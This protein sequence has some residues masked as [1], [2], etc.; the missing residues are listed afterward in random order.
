MNIYIRNFF[1]LLFTF[2][3]INLCTYIF[4]VTLYAVE[5]NLNIAVTHKT[6][7]DVKPGDIVSVSAQDGVLVPAQVT[8]D[9]KMFGVYIESPAFVLRTSATKPITRSG[10]ALVNVTTLSGEIN[11][12][13][14]LTSSPIKG[15]G[16]KAN[17]LGGF[18]LGIALDKFTQNDGTKLEY[19]KKT[20]AKG[21]I[22]VEV[23]IGPASPALTKTSG[24]LFGTAKQLMVNLLFN[25]SATRQAEKIIRYI[26]ASLVAIIVILI[27]FNTFG[28]NITRGIEAI[29]RNPL[30]KFSIQSMIVLNVV[31]IALVSLGGIILS[32]AILSL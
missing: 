10:V 11:P 16:Q 8:S 21:Q 32:L 18:M 26:I 12:G 4:P 31:L 27:N 5:G 19:E 29:G 9:P 28:K 15:H 13:D 1:I 22:K 7:D 14:Y 17:N 6:T 20:I 24:G 25:I 2:L 23:G 30:A 3:Y